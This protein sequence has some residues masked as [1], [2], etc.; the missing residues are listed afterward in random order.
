MRNVNW[1]WLISNYVSSIVFAA[2]VQYIA[3]GL[4]CRTILV[5]NTRA[6]DD[7]SIIFV[8]KKLKCKTQEEIK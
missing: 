2:V 3:L 6:T 7:Q 4:L 1:T 5:F 8:A